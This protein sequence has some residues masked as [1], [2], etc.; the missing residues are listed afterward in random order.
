MEGACRYD[1]S[2]VLNWV[3]NTCFVIC[4]KIVTFS[5]SKIFSLALLSIFINYSNLFIY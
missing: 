1:F 2:G 4:S 5:L 3:T